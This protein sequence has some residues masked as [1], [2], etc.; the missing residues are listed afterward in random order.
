MKNHWF[1]LTLVVLLTISAPI[2]LGSCKF[3]SSGIRGG[4]L[5]KLRANLKQAGFLVQD[6]KLTSVDVSTMCCSGQ[7]PTCLYNNFGVPYL[8]ITELPKSPGETD[9]PIF[10]STFHL[11]Q[12]EAIILVGQTP[13]PIAFF[14]YDVYLAAR[15]DT[16]FP[17]KNGNNTIVNAY[18]GDAINKLTIRTNGRHNYPFNQQILL[19]ITADRQVEARVQKAARRGGYPP[20][21]FNTF[22]IPSSI[23]KLGV[24]NQADTL[25][26]LQRGAIPDDPQALADYMA[27]P[28]TVLRVTLQDPVW[29]ADPLSIPRIR[30]HG[31]GQSEMELLPTLEALRQAIIAKYDSIP[32]TEVPV[33]AFQYQG[34]T[35]I[36][37]EQN[38]HGPTSDSLYVGT[39][40]TFMLPGPNSFAVLYGVNHELTGKATYSS[41]S[42]YEDV[43]QLG[44]GSANS[45]RD[46]LGSAAEYLPQDTPNVDKLFA[47][48]VA[49]DCQGE[50]Y[51]LEM[52]NPG[53]AALNLTEDSPFKVWFRQYLEPAT[54]TGPDLREVVNDRVILFTP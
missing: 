49:W 37:A 26:L 29:S 2:I 1:G 14:S 5:E 18:I 51:C 46:F 12:N 24:D 8:T 27:T 47:Y 50:K 11:G 39:T 41:L 17:P 4:N 15:Y 42:I 45:H 54:K 6:G 23:V 36:Q 3:P 40:G 52:I 20:S 9:M 35:G 38:G 33:E 25:W 30:V 7:I 13:P 22:V 44:L 16:R 48:K 21:M 53:C 10:P 31:T 28:Q 34:F 32:A 19:I 43:S